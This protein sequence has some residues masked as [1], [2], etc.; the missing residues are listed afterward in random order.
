MKLREG[1]WLEDLA[2][3]VVEEEGPL[4]V[5]ATPILHTVL[6]ALGRTRRWSRSPL[7]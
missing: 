4:P 1:F 5:S 6:A 7:R 3:P 2:K